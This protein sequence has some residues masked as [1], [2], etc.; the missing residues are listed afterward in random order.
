M[1][2]PPNVQ[3][4][5]DVLLLRE[6]VDVE[7]KRA[8]GQHGRGE[9][10][11]DFWPSYSALA[12]TDGG[13]IVLG[14]RERPDKTLQ[15]LGLPDV[16]RVRTDLWNLLNNRQK[17]SANVLQDRDVQVLREGE[18]Q[19]LLVRVPRADRRQRPVYVGVNPLEG[20]YRRNHAGDYLCSPDEVRRMFADAEPDSWPDSRILPGYSLD[21]LNTD[22]LTAYRNAF[23]SAKPGHR[24]LDLDDQGLLGQLGGWRRDRTSGEEGLTLAGLLMF[25]EYEVIRDV[26]PNFWLD[27]REVDPEQPE[28][29]WSDR[30]TMDGTWSGNLYDFYRLTYRRLVRDL[31]VPFQLRAGQ[32]ID[33]TP[34][35]EALR[36]ALANALAHAD[37]G[38]SGGV[39]I[40]K[41]RDGFSFRNPGTLRLPL[42]QVLEGG[43]TDPRNNSLHRMFLMMGAGE[44]AGSGIPKILGAWHDQHWRAPNLLEDVRPDTVTLKLTMQSLLPDSAAQALRERFG[45]EF[46][47]LSHD[48]RLALVTADVEGFVTNERL[49]GIT[50]LHSADITSML[51]SLA[52]RRMLHPEGAGRWTRYHLSEARESTML[53]LWEA[54]QLGVGGRSDLLQDDHTVAV[55]EAQLAVDEIPVAVD[56][57]RQHPPQDQAPLRK[58]VRNRDEMEQAI[59]RACSGRYLTLVEL[60]RVLGR[61]PV[62][63]G[64]QYIPRLVGTGRLTLLYPEAPRRKGQAYRTAEPP[65]QERA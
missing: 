52:N 59:L 33:D 27:Y 40:L 3:S 53:S 41:E 6:A 17:I 13:L 62:T 5:A 7:V 48:E 51:G 15:L 22:T 38:G 34:V 32:R 1:T 14:V 35:H 43:H 46:D 49:Q 54:A 21:D 25:S 23:K 55:D 37:Y 31:R 28:Q 10:P 45:A 63:L 39:V 18:C 44:R 24:W 58:R 2:A 26:I 30:L 65:S 47:A 61:S 29:R 60:G 11:H 36:E 9:L 57:A 56:E 4:F 16:E 64:N 12:N 42:E 8:Q 50:R 19:L 20:T